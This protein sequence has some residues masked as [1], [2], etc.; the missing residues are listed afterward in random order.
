MSPV[1][2]KTWLPSPLRNERA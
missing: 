1:G 2:Y